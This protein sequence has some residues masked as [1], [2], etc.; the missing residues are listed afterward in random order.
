MKQINADIE[1]KKRAALRQ[2]KPFLDQQA[3]GERNDDAAERKVRQS[4]DYE[5][6]KDAFAEAFN[7]ED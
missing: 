2:A 5:D 6:I 3:A 7:L 4:A 1:K